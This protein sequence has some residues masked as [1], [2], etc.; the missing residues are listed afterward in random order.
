MAMD[1]TAGKRQPGRNG[2][3]ARPR[4]FSIFDT[5]IK[6]RDSREWAL[7]MLV[8]LD[9]SP[10]ED[11][12]DAFFIDFWN[13]QRDIL[14]DSGGRAQDALAKFDSPSA[15]SF[16]AFAEELVGG[17]RANLDE[18]D[19]KIEGF[20]ENWTLSRI[21]EVDRNVLRMAFYELFFKED[22]PPAII[23]NEA[24]DIVKY[25]ST[26]ESGAF[27]NGILDTAARQV[28]RPMNYQVDEPRRGH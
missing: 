14:A 1:E 25:F 16:R 18:I 22:T 23:I 19:R 15:A 26:R 9:F 10:P 21:G 17:V 5:S 20:L 2:R 4:Q 8:A 28:N 11:G 6:R 3:P 7:Q 12:M 13:L 24:V 27:V